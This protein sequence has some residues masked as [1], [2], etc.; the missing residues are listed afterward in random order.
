[1]IAI[2]GSGFGLYGYLPAF[3]DGCTQRIVLQESYRGRFERRTELASYTDMIQWEADESSVLR[4]AKG[5]AIAL[6]PAD[7]VAFVPLC[8][9][10]TNIECLLLEKPLAPNPVLAANLFDKLISSRKKFRIGYSFRFTNW[11]QNLINQ[12]V[13]CNEDGV[14]FFEWSFLAHHF[15]NDLQNW[16]RFSLEGGGVVRFFGIHVIA[17]LA[18]IGYRN[19]VVSRAFG[20]SSNELEKW[21]AIF[22][23]N[24]LPR[25]EIVIDSNAELT[26]FHVEYH[27]NINDEGHILFANQC[28]PFEIENADKLQQQ[29]DSR[30]TVLKRLCRSLW[31]NESTEYTW[32]KDTIN[33]W[34]D[35]ESHMQF[36]VTI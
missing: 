20:K 27:S 25:C 23:G 19:V 36:E 13:S 22:T 4:V 29:L 11:G 34:H 31:E 28:D 26:K 17:L 15:A 33:L 21:I 14:L 9:E 18:E 6:R 30:I 3:V 32:Y 35:V 1:M 2:I 24:K 5:A 12:I 7:Q 8:L 16:K 10:Q